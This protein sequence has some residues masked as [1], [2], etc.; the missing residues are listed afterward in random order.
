VKIAFSGKAGSGKDYAVEYLISRLGGT[1]LAFAEPLVAGLKVLHHHY[2]FGYA[3]DRVLL[4]TVGDW[5]RRREPHVFIRSL[6]ERLSQLGDGN[7]Y[8]SDLRM[9]DEAIA[10]RG[11]GFVLVRVEDGRLVDTDSHK[12][13]TE[14]DSYEGFDFRVVNCRAPGHYEGCLDTIVAAIKEGR[15]TWSPHMTVRVS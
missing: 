7:V 14:L 1:R 11:L 6:A 5:A 13:E 15:H 9:R 3:K 8:V 12:S 10:L 2:G 4:Q